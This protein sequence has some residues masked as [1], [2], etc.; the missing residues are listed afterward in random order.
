MSPEP[1]T[2]SALTLGEGVPFEERVR[3]AAAAG[4]AGIG[5]RAEDYLAAHAAGLD[6]PGMEAVLRAHGVRVSEV[7]LVSDWSP[8]A[9]RSTAQRE[10]EETVLHVARAFGADHVNAALFQRRPR[11]EVVA[12]FAALCERAGEVRVALE[13]MPFGGLPD[14]AS[15]WDVVRRAG[16]PNAG[17]L[18]DAWHWSRSGAVASDLDPVPAKS[19]MAIQLSDVVE[20]PLADA[21]RETLH[22]RLAPG[23]GHGDPAG[24]V[25]ALHGRGVRAMVSV[26]VM[27]DDLL[28]LGPAACAERVMA[29]ARRVLSEA[30]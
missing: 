30:G 20:R 2:L 12:A 6:D 23:E 19:V 5:L 7:E 25:R 11:D 15:T 14:L 17:L 21:R 27:S 22:H 29:G 18:V 24:M 28:A 4:F 10:K 26:E 9:E 1:L 13:F 8:E 3:A 16:R